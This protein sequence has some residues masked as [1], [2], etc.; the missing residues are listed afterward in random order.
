MKLKFIFILFLMVGWKT[1]SAQPK[2]SQNQKTENLGKHLQ[3]NDSLFYV[4]IAKEQVEESL[5]S[6]RENADEFIPPVLFAMAQYFFENE[7]KDQAVF[8]YYV[9]LLRAMNDT[10]QEDLLFNKNKHTI[11]IY[12]QIFGRSIERYAFTNIL[13]TKNQILEACD[14][15]R[16]NPALYSSAWIYFDGA[17]KEKDILDLRSMALSSAEEEIIRIGTVKKFEKNLEKFLKGEKLDKFIYE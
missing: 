16:K 12:T 8:W 15:V 1:I 6:V 7:E 4:I 2:V 17:E 10:Q 13:Y 5:D 11:F 3:E 9:A 14:Y